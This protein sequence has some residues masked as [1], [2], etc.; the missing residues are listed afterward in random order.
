MVERHEH[1]DRSETG[2][3]VYINDN[4]KVHVLERKGL[5]RVYPVL[6]SYMRRK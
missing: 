1:D 6:L 4:E 5:V 3:Q 2:Y